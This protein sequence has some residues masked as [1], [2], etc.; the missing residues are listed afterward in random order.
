[1]SYS[2]TTD[3]VTKAP[4]TNFSYRNVG[5]QILEEETAFFEAS[6]VDT[7]SE[8]SL[9]GGVPQQD[10]DRL[11]AEARTQAAAD[12]RGHMQ[13]EVARK[14]DEQRVSAQA[15][16]HN[17]ALEQKK[18]FSLIESEVV[19]LSLSIAA[20][21]LHREAQV[22]PLLIA[23][24][25][26]VAVEKLASGSSVTVL[27]SPEQSEYWRAYRAD[28]SDGLHVVVVEDLEMKATDCILETELGSADFS[29]AAQLKEVERG[30][31]DLLALRPQIA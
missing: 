5:S 21:I 6:S 15:A 23:G 4:V 10:V 19:K 18:Y 12:V 24:L 30:F 1:M 9:T 8:T 26:R 31:F 29:M 13:A 25:V 7:P 27:F 11:I 3:K 22:D 14:V 20:R 28:A 16:L 17:F 2:S